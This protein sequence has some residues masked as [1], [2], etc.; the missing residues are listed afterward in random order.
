MVDAHGKPLFDSSMKYA[1]HFEKDQ[2][3][4]VRAF[5]SLTMYNDK[6]F[7]TDNPIDRYA[8]GDRDDLKFNDDGSLDPYI[9]RDAPSPNKENNWLPAPK[10]GGFSLTLRLYWPKASVLDGTWSPPPVKPLE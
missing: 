10:E 7:F 3:P 8:I 4:P 6:Q 5:W 9:Q 1:L 2:I